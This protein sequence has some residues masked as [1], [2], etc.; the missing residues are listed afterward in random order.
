MEQKK[1]LI[2]ITHSIDN[3]ELTSIA[4]KLASAA[5]SVNVKPVI[6]LQSE[7]VRL[8]VKGFAEILNEEGVDS[9]YQYIKSY[10][11]EG[12]KI[13]VCKT[14]MNKRKIDPHTLIEQAEVIGVPK[15]MELI[16]ECDKVVKY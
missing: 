13:Y 10:L 3:I 11:D 8:A 2:I 16:L 7:G 4:V 14:C 9:P 5:I 6:A 15:V 1:M 12:N